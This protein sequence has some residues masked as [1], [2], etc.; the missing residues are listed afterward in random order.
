MRQADRQGSFINK[1][2]DTAKVQ[3]LWQHV[4]NWVKFYA[5]N[6]DNAVQL[7]AVGIALVAALA[8]APTARRSI[9]W[10]SG[11]RG[12]EAWLARAGDILA[13]FAL[14]FTWIVILWISALS[15]EQAGWPDHLLTI[16]LSLL[17]AS[18]VIH[19]ATSLIRE[20]AIAKL[21]TIAV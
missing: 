13:A 1:L 6:L 8:L 18:I 4:L 7:G 20:P 15:G 2:F 21:V 10:L 11:L 5:L 12:N 19:L 17:T 3:Q 16:A 9:I 14:P